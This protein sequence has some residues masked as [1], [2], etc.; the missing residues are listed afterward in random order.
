MF[1]MGDQH[2]CTREQSGGAVMLGIPGKTIA[3]SGSSVFLYAMQV[4]SLEVTE[5]ANHDVHFNSLSFFYSLAAS[6][7]KSNHHLCSPPI[8][9]FSPQFTSTQSFLSR[10]TILALGVIH[11]LPDYNLLQICQTEGDRLCQVTTVD[12]MAP[13]V[14]AQGGHVAA[15]TTPAKT[16]ASNGVITE[17]PAPAVNRKKAKR[18][19]KDKARREAAASQ[20]AAE[21]DASDELDDTDLA[22]PGG[23]PNPTTPR[24]PPEL[25]YD[26]RY[27]NHLDQYDDPDETG[28]AYS[29]E[30]N[31]HQDYHQEYASANGGNQHADGSTLG[32]RN[33]KK[34]KKEQDSQYESYPEEQAPVEYYHPPPPR[35]RAPPTI[36]EDAL[37]TVEQKVNDDVWETAQIGER[38]KIRQFW[39]Q[40]PEKERRELVKIEKDAV[41]KKM[42]EQQKHSCSCT[43]CGRK[44]TAIE[45]ELEL[46]YNAYYTEL[47][48]Y[49]SSGQRPPQ[50]FSP[51]NVGTIP[52]RPSFS[53][54]KLPSHGRIQEYPDD[55]EDDLDDLEDEYDEG[56]GYGP[57]D[58]GG[59]NQVMRQ[60]YDTFDSRRNDFFTFGQNLTVKNGLLTVGDELLNN[61][62]EKFIDMMEQL[63][64]ARMRRESEAYEAY[65]FTHNH[66]DPHGH[67]Y[68]EEDDYDD[69][70]EYD[71]DESQLDEYEEDDEMVCLLPT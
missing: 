3:A 20:R 17:P 71:D 39:L 35:P 1:W 51:L 26:P 32:K 66:H 2:G 14:K 40:L 56:D 11:S 12:N 37:R 10:A 18:R 19:A 25:Q 38:H 33:K 36:T 29:D 59:E 65:R 50:S 41:L 52:Q 22:P 6:A 24:P 45:E 21:D 44:R 46:L 55:E 54:T 63:A 58:Y 64:T 15:S 42:K 13:S 69:E 48:Q 23:Y 27:P 7:G 60:G 67:H 28:Y 53:H 61:H 8:K 5:D 4:Q 70:E 34:K 31:P 9:H 43:V 30:E 57:E 62:G 16:P 68:S 47:E 49:A